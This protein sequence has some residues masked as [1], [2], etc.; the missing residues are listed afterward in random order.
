MACL[1]VLFSLD[2]ETVKKLLAFQSDEERLNFVQEEIEEK[3]M[4]NEP[5][6]FA[7]FDK[8]W[9]ALHRSLT[10]GRFDWS[11]GTFP[12]NHVILGGQQIYNED[13]YIM[14]LKTPEQVEKINEAIQKITE[15]D[16]RN[17]YNKIDSED[18]GFDL[19]DEDFEYTWTWFK[20]ALAFWAKAALEKRYVL[21]T[22]DQ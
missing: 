14:S 7:E 19:T 5:E 1:G 17:G 4:T 11:N 22:V 13:D 12:L 3:I 2:H 16:L 21:F 20:D 10:D 15:I 9:D 6:R 8:S 18:Y